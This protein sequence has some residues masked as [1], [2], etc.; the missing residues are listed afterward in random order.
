M[1]KVMLD[2]VDCALE[3]LGYNLSDD[4]VLSLVKVIKDDIDNG[5]EDSE[6]IIK[7]FNGG[8]PNDFE[9]F[10][11]DISGYII[12]ESELSDEEKN[13]EIEKVSKN[14]LKYA[15]KFKIER[16]TD[17]DEA[18]KVAEELYNECRVNEDKYSKYI[19]D[20]YYGLA[21]GEKLT[22]NLFNKLLGILNTDESALSKLKKE[23]ELESNFDDLILDVLENNKRLKKEFRDR[24]RR[25]EGIF[26][27]VREDLIKGKRLSENE[28]K[29]VDM[30]LRGEEF[31]KN[32]F[33]SAVFKYIPKNLI[34]EE[35]DNVE[36]NKES[37]LYRFDGI[38]HPSKIYGLFNFKDGKPFAF[39]PG[40]DEEVEL[41]LIDEDGVSLL[42]VPM[43]S[44]DKLKLDLHNL[45]MNVYKNTL[46][47]I[48]FSNFKVHNWGSDRMYRTDESSI[49]EGKKLD[50]ERQEE[51]D[52]AVEEHIKAKDSINSLIEIIFNYSKDYRKHKNTF[53]SAKE[54]LDSLLD[55]VRDCLFENE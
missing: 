5:N 34:D 2:I 13:K 6:E 52:F 42:V 7:V 19:R 44:D 38:L 10:K 14:I 8:E 43:S 50:K 3:E 20:I 39:V 27:Y 48:N 15:K 25:R 32:D 24:G 28:K 9:K 33:E 40:I 16:L 22:V 41:D 21:L 31:D 1:S 49:D 37:I 17:K 26:S 36:T 51:Y 23:Y 54:N 35:V 53:K 45:F 46:D 47:Y 11:N 12:D 55:I 4:E 30:A 18:R 29:A